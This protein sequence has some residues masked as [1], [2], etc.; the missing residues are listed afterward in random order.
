[1]Q[2]LLEVLQRLGFGTNWRNW[3]SI[4]LAS[5]SSK[6]LLNGTLVKPIKHERDLRQGDPISPM[7]FILTMDPLQRLLIIV[8]EKGIMHS[9]SP[10]AKGIKAS[11][12][13]DD[14][15]IFVSPIKQDITALKSILDAFGNASGLRTNLQKTE[16]SQLAVTMFI[17][18]KF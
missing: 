5:S 12:Y 2:P 10:R 14:A 1:M 8:A 18:S 7:L 4:A 11:L 6:V 9:I 17:W 13:T 16:F 15:S 3:I